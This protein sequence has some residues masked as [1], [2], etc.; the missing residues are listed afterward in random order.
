MKR[1]WL[2]SRPTLKQLL[3]RHVWTVQFY[4]QLGARCDKCG[5]VKI[6][7]LPRVPRRTRRM[8]KA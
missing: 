1:Y 5:M 3:C 6:P 7:S 4:E 8:F 2:A